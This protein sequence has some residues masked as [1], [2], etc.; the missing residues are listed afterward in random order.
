MQHPALRTARIAKRWLPQSRRRPARAHLAT[1]S[2]TL[3]RSASVDLLDR[4]PSR[5][6]A[7]HPFC[8]IGLS[9]RLWRQDNGCHGFVQPHLRTSHLAPRTSHLARRRSTAHPHPHPSR[10]CSCREPD[11]GEVR[12]AFC[13]PPA[14]LPSVLFAPSAT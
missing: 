12:T 7:D 10:S 5:A 11:D 2:T 9:A 4:A 13:G 8:Y 3:N 1:T 14:L 6:A